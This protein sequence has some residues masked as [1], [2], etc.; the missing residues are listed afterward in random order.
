MKSKFLIYG[1]ALT[2]MAGCTTSSIKDEI[3]IHFGDLPNNP[4][5]IEQ[6][7]KGGR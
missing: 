1:F 5:V 4:F 2:A 3:K 7:K 6:A